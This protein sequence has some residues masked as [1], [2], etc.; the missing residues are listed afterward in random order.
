MD[1]YSNTFIISVT[2]FTISASFTPGPNNVMLLSSGLT[3]G[4][5]KSIP[6]ILGVVLGYPL[7]FICIGLGMQSVLKTYPI[8]LEIIKIV[9][10]GYLLF[11]AYKIGTNN[12]V[13][14]NKENKRAFT[15]IEAALF[16]WLN[17]KAWIFSITAISIFI[18]PEYNTMIQII[19]FAFISFVI[20]SISSTTWT[21]G[22]VA[23]K[24]LISKQKNIKIFNQTMAVLLI[25]SMLPVFFQ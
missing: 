25:V 15:F 18:S 21:F 8:F 11:M 3:F 16:Q 9:G 17:P 4:F 6:H 2:M 23:L 24:T 14:D 19:I 22:G 10:M 7:M 13:Y 5:K 20:A 12:D 1:Y